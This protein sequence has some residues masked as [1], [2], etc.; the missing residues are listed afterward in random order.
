MPAE[1][2]QRLID[3]FPNI[4][5][6]QTYGQTEGGPCGTVLIGRDVQERIGSVGLP[7]AQTEL[8]VVDTCGVDVP[9]DDVGEIIVR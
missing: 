4:N 3:K 1:I 7:W 6:R 2:T 9:V 8:R 5:I